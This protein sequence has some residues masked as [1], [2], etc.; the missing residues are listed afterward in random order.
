MAACLTS[1]LEPGHGLGG[2]VPGR[3]EVGL[4]ASVDDALG[5][6][7]DFRA[8][9]LGLLHRRLDGGGAQGGGVRLGG[10]GGGEADHV[11]AQEPDLVGQGRS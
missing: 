9:L 2:P 7:E 11:L 10:G 8:P 5:G 1:S 4:V 6:I 3:L